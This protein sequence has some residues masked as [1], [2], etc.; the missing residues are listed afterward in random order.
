MNNP[1]ACYNHA[2]LCPPPGPEAGWGG[3]AG[4]SRGTDS[5]SIHHQKPVEVKRWVLGLD[6]R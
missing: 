6:D 2:A 3:E 5:Q 4:E 1:D